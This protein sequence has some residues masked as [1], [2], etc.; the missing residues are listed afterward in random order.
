VFNIDAGRTYW[1]GVPTLRRELRRLE[2][3]VVNTHMPLPGIFGRIA[4]WLARV[5]C[6]HTEQLPLDREKPWIRLVNELT[7]NAVPALVCI[8]EEVRRTV[9]RRTNWYLL[10]RK[11]V[12]VITNSVDVARLE[13]SSGEALQTRSE[14]GLR[15]DDIVIVNVGRYDEQK[16]QTYLLK[17]M[18]AIVRKE[19][20]ARLVLVGWGPLEETLR[21]EV[22][23]LGLEDHVVLAV[24]RPDAYRIV[25]AGDLFVFPSLFEGL[26]I[27]LLEAM[28]AGKPVV[29]TDIAPL[30]EVVRRDVDGVLVPAADPEAIATAVLGL[31]GDPVRM[32]ALG[33][34][35]RARVRAHFGIE[36]SATAY[37]RVFFGLARGTS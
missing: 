35:A 24:E 14:L 34:A 9:S 13:A 19:P 31:L 37:E 6:V 3:D 12:H 27:A 30:T 2:I 29:A 20:R 4:A 1:R 5:P 25:V 22:H 17:A 11:R 21:A 26:G 33:Q 18:R 32:S 28:A 15:Q 7:L 23:E 8:S 10:R 16:G 36:R